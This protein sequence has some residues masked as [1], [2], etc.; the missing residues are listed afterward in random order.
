MYDVH[1]VESVL[2]KRFIELYEKN[3]FLQDFEFEIKRKRER[4]ETDIGTEIEKRGE[5]RE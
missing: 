3:K 5:K 2:G 1:F 4:R